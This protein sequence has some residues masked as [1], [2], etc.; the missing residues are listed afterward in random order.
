MP[1]SVG[2]TRRALAALY[3]ILT[4]LEL[5]L[6]LGDF[7]FQTSFFFFSLRIY[8][9]VRKILMQNIWWCPGLIYSQLD[10]KWVYLTKDR[11]ARERP[12]CLL[13]TYRWRKRISQYY[14]KLISIC[15][16]SGSNQW[17]I[18]A[19]R[20]SEIIPASKR[21]WFRTFYEKQTIFNFNIT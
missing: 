1:S 15:Q 7:I 18:Y 13:T 11:S 14:Y 4:A 21:I 3:L 20:L 9:E 5:N 17:M 19:H 10:Y 12:S 6:F 2:S 8:S 16:Y